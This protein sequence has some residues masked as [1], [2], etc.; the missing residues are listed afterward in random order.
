MKNYDETISS[1]FDRISEYEVEK[2]RKRKMVTRTVTSL[3]CFCLVALLGIGVWHSDIFNTTPPAILDGDNS[4]PQGT[5]KNDGTKPNNNES[6][7][8]RPDNPIIWGNASGDVGAAG[9]IEWNGKTITLPLYG[10]LS[11]EKNK[12]SLIAISAGFELD[13]KFVCNGKSLAEYAAEAEGERLLYDKLGSLLKV[14]DELKYGEDLY[15]IGTPD[16]KKWAKE[17]YQK[18]VADLGEDLISKYIVNGEF[19]KEK[20]EFDIANYD[21]SEPCRIA[22]EV[23]CEAYYQFIIDEVIVQL[24]NQTVNYERRNSTELV[25]YATADELSSLKI[26]NVLFYGL[27]LKD[28]EGMDMS[29]K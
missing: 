25:I 11:D 22:Y 29:E 27:A 26:D 28:D 17:L 8:I 3:C 15:T 21:E 6:A 4:N 5:D 18:T 16:G 14:G 1:V 24:E 19:L 10:V 7:G 12:N 23:A 2:K 9:Y 20:L 13:E